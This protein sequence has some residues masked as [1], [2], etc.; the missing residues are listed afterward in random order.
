M[1]ADNCEDRQ[2]AAEIL[3]CAP[4]CLLSHNGANR[5]QSSSLHARCFERSLRAAIGRPPH[6]VC[7]RSCEPNVGRAGAQ[8]AVA[9][10]ARVCFCRRRFASAPL[11]LRRKS[12]HARG[13]A[14]Q[15]TAA[16]AGVS[17]AA[18][19]AHHYVQ[20]RRLGNGDGS[21]GVGICNGLSD[22]R[23]LGGH[24]HSSASSGNDTGLYGQYFGL[25]L[26]QLSI[27]LDTEIVR[28]LLERRPHLCKLDI[29]GVDGKADPNLSYDED[30]DMDDFVAYND[31]DNIDDDDEEFDD[32]VGADDS[33][34]AAVAASHTNRY[35]PDSGILG[36]TASER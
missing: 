5:G 32:N 23:E 10:A 22:T 14:L 6:A 18:H 28:L 34:E 11:V 7:G 24:Q 26:E 1:K 27:K 19:A 31:D 21:V 3:A 15:Q 8:H 36:Q 12:A 4:L 9:G 2:K 33:E 13:V 25:R 35:V 17:V 16:P 29:L 20:C 30:I